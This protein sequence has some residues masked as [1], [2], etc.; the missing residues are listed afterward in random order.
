MSRP[1][2]AN[3]SNIAVIESQYMRW[4]ENPESVDSDWQ[5]FFQ[6]FELR[7]LLTPYAI[8]SNQ[9]QTAVVRLIFAYRDLGHFLAHL[10]PLTLPPTTHPLLELSQ[11]G[12]TEADLDREVDCSAVAGMGQAKLRELVSILRQIYCGT[13]GYE[14]MHIQ[15]INVRAWL[16]ERI[17]P[18]RSQPN[19]PRR[20]RIRVLHDLHHSEKFEHFLHTRY[21]GQKRFSLEGA[22]TLIPVLD[23]IVEKSP[24]LGAQELVVGM[25]HRGRLNVLANIMHKPYHEIF[26]EFEDNPHEGSFSGD[27]DVK[28]HLGFSSNVVTT[29][30]K[31]VHL[32]L[33]PNPSHLEAVNPVV[34]GRVRAKQ[35][36]FNDLERKRGVPV[37]VHGDAAFAGQGMVAE[38]LN[39]SQL[40]GYR[41]GGTIHVIV[42]NQIGFTTT[43]NDARSTTYC[44][45]VAKMIQA[46]IFHV[47]AEDPDAAVFIAELA[48]EFRQT[49]GRDVVID[50]YCYRKYGHN[51]GDEPMFTQ[52]VMYRKIKGRPSI[53]SL[54]S[55][56]IIREAVFT[57]EEV[58][59]LNDAYE[60]K[61]T[62]V[63]EE[64]RKA[65]LPKKGMASYMDN[66]SGLQHRYHNT[67]V[68]TGVAEP[69]LGRIIDQLTRV[70]EGF[71][72]EPKMATMLEGRRASFYETKQI[73]WALGELLAFGSL[74]LE[75]THVRLSGQDCRRGTFSQRHSV[76]YHNQSGERYVPFNHFDPPA[77]TTFSVY[78]S[79]L[80]ENAVLGF[81]FGYSMDSPNSL[82]IWEAQFGDFAN[83][84]QTIIDQFIVCSSSKWQRS[85]GLVMMLPHGYE[86][87]GPEHSSARL[88]RFL[89]SCAEDNIQVAYCT[90]AA[91]HFHILRRQMKR[92]FRIPLILMTPKSL[93]RS[94]LAA[95]PVSEFVGGQFHE[96]IGD[97][98]VDPAQVRRV[99]LCTGKIYHDLADARFPKPATGANPAASKTSNPPHPD[100]ALIRIEQLYPFPEEALQTELNRYKNAV[101]LVWVQEE[102]QNM[103]AWSFVEPRLRAMGHDAQYIGRDASASPAT[104]SPKIHKAEQDEIIRSTFES[105]APVIVRA[106][107]AGLNRQPV[108]DQPMDKSR[109]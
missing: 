30:G 11:F 43:P 62:E 33:T 56:Q 49:F 54:Y 78:D 96:V 97:T 26:A 66:W 92:N 100:V 57:E 91:Q 28:Y 55:E 94:P 63:R 90:T 44:T 15:D 101:E 87:Q 85:S 102:S 105:P 29:S 35:R 72:I 9:L 76:L 22:E 18:R 39:L 88:E 82:V 34:E 107:S 65:K 83:G 40:S 12:L 58:S 81:E 74:I 52:P 6:G 67:P 77:P 68:A 10:D 8:E 104:G 17:E 73:D 86:G 7:G 50:M 71:S 38:T 93:L 42:N 69:T 75:G 98:T 84:A 36:R 70:P 46:P 5:V 64:V 14:F 99:V 95:S 16:R 79:L 47:N 23:A 48:L 20:Q 2:F 103:G 32:S 89:Q 27:G 109:R 19:L 80:S 108:A 21:V 31:T 53:A 41:T 61:L 24:D 1:S 60:Q 45:D 3:M 106:D 25:A 59:D 13:I 51:E 4:R 37:L